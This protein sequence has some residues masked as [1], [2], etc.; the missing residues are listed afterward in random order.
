MEDYKLS[1]EKAT[2]HAFVADHL[3]YTTYSLLKDK[4]LLLKILEELYNAS[5]N[6]INTILQYDYLYK[7]INLYK[8][9]RA[10]FQ[11]FREKC[12][13]RYGISPEQISK[14]LEIFSLIEKHRQSPF[15]F[16]KRDRLVIMSNGMAIDTLSIEKMKGFNLNVKDMIRKAS[17]KIQGL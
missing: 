11:T 17:I 5:L 12:A 1:L 9:S 16:M 2:K 14:I 7:R 15:E 6:L 4:R 3:I 13:P 10:N 8:D